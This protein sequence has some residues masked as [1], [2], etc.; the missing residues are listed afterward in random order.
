MTK[1]AR[2]D[3]GGRAEGDAGGDAGRDAA[4]ELER[5]LRSLGAVFETVGGKLLGARVVG[6]D[7]PPDRVAISPEADEA[8][9]RAG[10]SVGRFLHAAGEGLK[11]HPLRPDAAF[12]VARDH[13][14]DE[15]HPPEGY[16]P[17]TA[18]IADLGV[19]LA[20]VAEGVLDAVAPRRPKPPAS[21]GAAEPGVEA[22]TPVDEPEGNEP[23]GP[24]DEDDAEE[25]PR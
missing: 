19:G 9:V 20:K 23:A 24:V 7:V 3:A 15:L 16:T 14:E 11:A 12:Q 18:G 17:L 1:D 5:S 8:L 22:A 4:S 6:K 13:A 2:E 10:E 25:I 21:E